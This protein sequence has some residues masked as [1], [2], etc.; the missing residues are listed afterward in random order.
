M[1][2]QLHVRGVGGEYEDERKLGRV[3]ARFGEVIQ[4]TVRHRV[5]ESGANTS[6]AL[7]TLGSVAAV[8]DAIAAADSL[9]K[10]L[11]VAR[12]NRKQ[13]ASSKGAMGAIRKQ[14]AAKQ[15][16]ARWRQREAWK[17]TML[18]TM[19]D[20]DGDWNEESTAPPQDVGAL[21]EAERLAHTAAKKH[22]ATVTQELEGLHSRLAAEQEA[23]RATQAQL[24]TA[25]AAGS[26]AGSPAGRGGSRVAE[27]QLQQCQAELQRLQPL[28]A[29]ATERAD[30]AEQ[31][32]ERLRKE[33][34]QKEAM[35]ARLETERGVA[36]LRAELDAAL[37][38]RPR[39]H[40]ISA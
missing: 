23:H 21:L 17:Q 29:A 27:L 19:M 7:V 38:V 24:R 20:F 18:M 15:I 12:F 25:A 36:G 1:G 10:P 13:A 16:Q 5:D 14:A 35:M 9:P 3:F 11:T 22:N 31:E 2:C 37:A 33:L 30:A 4:A 34:A 6:W 40:L 39:Y 8:E 32:V 28:E 26:P